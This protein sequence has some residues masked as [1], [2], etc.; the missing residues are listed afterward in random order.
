MDGYN[1]ANKKRIEK[2]KGSQKRK[3]YYYD[4]INLYFESNLE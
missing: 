2:G 4:T 1:N 3:I